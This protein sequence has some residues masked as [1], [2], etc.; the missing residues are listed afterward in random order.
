MKYGVYSYSMYE[1]PKDARYEAKTLSQR[2]PKA[3][4]YINDYEEQTVK[5]GDDET[6]TQAW[7]NEMR[8]LLETR[9]SFLFI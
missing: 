4:F 2:A 8:S 6:A 3:A 5:S 9:R 1:S 7:A